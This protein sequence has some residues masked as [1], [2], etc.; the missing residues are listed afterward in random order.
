MEEGGGGG[1]ESGRKGGDGRR[2]KVTG[3]QNRA[4]ACTLPSVVKFHLTL[5]Y[6]A[7]WI[8]VVRLSVQLARCSVVC[9]SLLRRRLPHGAV[10][11][12][13]PWQLNVCRTVTIIFLLT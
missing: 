9:G 12:L 8:S 5:S 6:L 2:S 7:C 3:L 1:A 13:F 11:C 4:T 10:V